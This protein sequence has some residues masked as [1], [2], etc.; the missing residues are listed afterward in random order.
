MS[1]PIF[2]AKFWPTP[3]SPAEVRVELDIRPNTDDC[4][5]TGTV[6]YADGSIN[7]LVKTVSEA[8]AVP[9]EINDRMKLAAL[10]AMVNL[11]AQ[12][13]ADTRAQLLVLRAQQP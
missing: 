12:Q 4:I 13:L 6:T 2:E 3:T 11:L 1:E 7:G 5:I 10:Y 9:G 8:S